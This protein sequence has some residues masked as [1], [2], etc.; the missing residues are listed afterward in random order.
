MEGL[1][2]RIDESI[3]DFN[4]DTNLEM[5]MAT[6]RWAIDKKNIQQGFTAF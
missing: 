2:S 5:G 4:V 6:V 1:L 3:A